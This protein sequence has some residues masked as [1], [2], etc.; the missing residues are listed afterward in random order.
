MTKNAAPPATREIG[1]GTH[2]PPTPIEETGSAL[3]AG[4]VW[5]HYSY[6]RERRKPKPGPELDALEKAYSDKL[7]EFQGK[8]GELEHVYWST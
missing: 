8:V 7:K 1:N 6:E 2:A 4:L 5:A 3:F